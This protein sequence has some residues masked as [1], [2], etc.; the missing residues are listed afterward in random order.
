MKISTILDKIDENQ[1]FVPAFQREFVWSRENVK[2]LKSSKETKQFTKL[3]NN[4]I[5]HN[6]I[7]IDDADKSELE[8]MLKK[9]LELKDLS[10]KL[11][12][13]LDLLNK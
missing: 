13:E 9:C 1:L 5:G 2:Q 4:L 10:V 3:A 8:K 11:Q 7:N 12:K 6:K